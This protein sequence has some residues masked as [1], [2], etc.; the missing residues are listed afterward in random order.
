[1][2]LA[3][4]SWMHKLTKLFC[5][6]TWTFYRWYLICHGSCAH[7]GSL[8]EGMGWNTGV[9]TWTSP[10]RSKRKRRQRIPRCTGQKSEISREEDKV[11]ERRWRGG[12]RQ[13][14]DRWAVSCIISNCLIGSEHHWVS[15]EFP[16][17]PSL[18]GAWILHIWL[19]PNMEMWRI[20]NKFVWLGRGGD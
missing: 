12:W 8:Q 18:I 15:K 19:F 6:R 3:A 5:A 2:T 1:M 14:H 7:A 17:V 9:L 20:R 16:A 4:C 11:W 10:A 13:R